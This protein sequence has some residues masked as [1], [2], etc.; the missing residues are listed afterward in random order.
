MRKFFKHPRLIIAAIA[1]ITVFFALQLVKAEMN[2]NNIR[3]V[4]EDDPALLASEEID[5]VFGSSLYIVVG[6]ERRWGTILDPKLLQKIREYTEF[7]D[8][9]CEIVGDI[10]S[11]MNA[12]YITASADSI[13][14]E[15]LVPDDFTGTAG[16]LVTLR[17][18]LLSW[19]MYRRS[20]VSDDFT[21]TQILI[22]LEIE[23]REAGDKLAMDTFRT[24]R[25][26]A[27]EMFDPLATVYLAGL[28]V[29]SS[30][31]NEA[32]EADLTHLIPL[33]VLV[34]L[35]ILFFS[36][37]RATA[38]FLPLITVIV[39]VIWSI[40]AMPLL[41]IK[42]SV[43]TTVLP[44]ILVAVGSAYGIHV[45][46]HY[47]EDMAE[48]GSAL[49]KAEHEDLVLALLKKI[50]KPVMLAALT[51]FSG[52]VSFCFTTVP[53]IR[54]F[55]Y[56]SS[57]GVIVSFIVA[58]TLIPALLLVRGP[59]PM[60]ISS[61]KHKRRTTNSLDD[62]L[63]AALTGVAKKKRFV[64][65]CAGIVTAISLYGLSKVIIDNV[66]VEYFK[67]DTDVWQSDGFV[68]AQFGGAKAVNVVVEAENSAAL[69]APEVLSALDGLH[70][71]LQE[72]VPSIGKV[73]GFTDLVKRTNQV[74][75]AD[76]PP[77]GIRT[78]IINDSGNSDN[79]G[80]DFGF[81]DFV[82]D[83][84]SSD[85]EESGASLYADGDSIVPPSS[86][87]EPYITLDVLNKTADAPNI[88]AVDLLWKVKRLVNY[89]GASYYE[90][91][92]D[93]VRY[94]KTESAELST[95][96]SNYLVLLSGSTSD[97][98]N[99]PLEP[100]VIKTTLQLQT[101][102]DADTQAA[103]ALARS[104]I[105]ANFPDTVTVKIAG[106][107]LVD[108]SL[109]RRVVDT[110]I[111]SIAVSLFMV[112][113]IIAVA[114]KSLVAGLMGSGPLLISILINFAVMGFL[115]IKL[116]MITSLVASVSIGIGIDYT[117]HLIESY[118]REYQTADGKDNFLYRAFSTSG[119]AIVINAVSVGAGFAVLIFS[120]FN[121]LA[122]LGLLMALT[123]FTSAL[124]SLTVIPAVL[125]LTK[126]AF[127]YG[128][129]KRPQG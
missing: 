120:Q 115:G 18:K 41:G 22:P 58:V 40:G 127:I 110:Q 64:L 82:F 53:P 100:T 86:S 47:M 63:A 89:E 121:V 109:T 85:D 113:A 103:L 26:A 34:V 128:S 70:A 79:E 7:I 119:R 99:D 124:I 87:H 9:Q 49:T 90:I 61:K 96:V 123:M 42:L 24:I 54:E 56:F 46:T 6:L 94:G 68:R 62:E 69:L 95:L 12:D 36:F 66:Y 88:S 45:V 2:N 80:G 44:V 81:G 8:G 77:G 74:F 93:P 92:V 83:D 67:P 11:I 60:K 73:M 15:N 91:P 105:D 27:H 78:K 17:E 108:S 50:G 104:Y 106:P 102:G 84:Y 10:T 75:N 1:G 116:N 51:T 55:G 117:I 20:L 98:A 76:E 4:P 31:S 38:V 125:S 30:T 33:V 107:A 72:R 29:I 122:S 23:N 114:Q 16:E 118:K 71:Y 13:V 5:D 14:V 28:P 3:F 19:D 126:P 25:G 39:A 129:N 21:A 97:Y 32:T 65:A 48:K 59:K 35:V 111:V 57:F 52:F 101:T 43:I 37:R 112:F